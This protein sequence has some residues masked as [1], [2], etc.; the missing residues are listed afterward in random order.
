[1]VPK[2]ESQP[3]DLERY[4]EFLHRR[5]RRQLG[6]RLRRK[7]DAAD[8]VQETLLQAHQK[9]AQFRGQTEAELVSWLR[10][11]LEN[12]LGMTMRQFRA[13]ARD[14]ARER[15]LHY[16]FGEAGPCRKARPTA[17]PHTPD[18]NLLRQ[19]QFRRLA[20]ALAELP[21]HQRQAIEL[22]HLEGRSLAEV[23]EQMHKSRD[24]VIGLLFRGLKSLRRLLAEEEKD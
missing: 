5:A 6:W 9:R 12:T 3:D 8:L 13:R 14:V 19:E 23:A 17:T 24:A 4:R 2:L 22:H 10:T 18:E 20:D 21:P 16:G 1:M 7:L 11:I 15:S